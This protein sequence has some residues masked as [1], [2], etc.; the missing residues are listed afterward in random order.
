MSHMRHFVLAAGMLGC[1]VGFSE[2]G[3]AQGIPRN[4]PRNETLILENPAFPGNSSTVTV[5]V[6][7]VLRIALKKPTPPVRVALTGKEA[8]ASLLLKWTVPA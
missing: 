6:P 1:L 5:R 3:R 7:A 4:L 8:W 2:R